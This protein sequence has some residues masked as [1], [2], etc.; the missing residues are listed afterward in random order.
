MNNE[1]VLYLTAGEK[2]LIIIAPPVL[3]GLLG[4]FVPSVAEWVITLPFIP[5][6]GV[7]EWIASVESEWVSVLPVMIGVIVGIIFTYYVFTESLK[8]TIRDE[9]V[10]LSVKN[11]RQNIK[12]RELSSVYMDGKYLVFLNKHGEELYRGRPESK[13]EL[14][15]EAFSQYEYPWEDRDPYEDHYQRWVRDHP[16]YSRHVNALLAAREKALKDLETKEAEV[17]RKDLADLG[18]VIRDKGKRQYVRMGTER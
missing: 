12:K 7:L 13:K 11:N 5:F 14:V 8:I 17:L 2:A 1:T 18:I 6:Q 9:E 4:W 3:G 15:I 16:D 10:N